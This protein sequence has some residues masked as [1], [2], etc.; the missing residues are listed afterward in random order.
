MN[1]L[2]GSGVMLRA[3]SF[4]FP[5]GLGFGVFLDFAMEGFSVQHVSFGSV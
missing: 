3:A 4:P 1:T 2:P 5:V